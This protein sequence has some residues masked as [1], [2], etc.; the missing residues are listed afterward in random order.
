MRRSCAVPAA[1]ATA[2]SWNNVIDNMGFGVGLAE[3]FVMVLLTLALWTPA[4]IWILA[5]SEWKLGP[6]LLENR[7]FKDPEC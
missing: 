3:G 4:R 1:D 5:H 7:H 2:D 6:D